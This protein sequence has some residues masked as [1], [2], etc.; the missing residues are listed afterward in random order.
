[1][2]TVDASMQ[3]V[4]RILAASFDNV[5]LV[6]DG[7]AMERGST[8]VR[9]EVNEWGKDPNGEPSSIIRIWAPLV[10]ALTP[11]PDFYHWAAVDGQKFLFGSVTTLDNEDGTCFVTFDYTLLADYLDPD[12]LTQAVIAVAATANDLDDK[13]HE[14]FGGLRYVDPNPGDAK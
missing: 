10:R 7:F 5:M 2:A 4:Q 12:E 9:V 3:K 1:M 6:K 11:S 8:R 14:K 13:V